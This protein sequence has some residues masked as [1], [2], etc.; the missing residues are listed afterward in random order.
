MCSDQTSCSE[1]LAPP[2]AKLVKRIARGVV[3]A[4][5]PGPSG[6]HD[7]DI[8]AIGL[9]GRTSCATRLDRHLDS[10]AK[11]W[12]SA[13]TA[14]LDCGPKKPEPGQQ[15]PQPCPRKLHPLA[16]AEVLVKLA[17]SCANEQHI[18]TLLKGVEPTNLGL[19]T[20]D[21]AAPVVRIVRGWAND[22]VVARKEGQDADVV[23]PVDLENAYGRAFRSTCLE[24]ARSA[25][26]QLA[27]ICAAQWEPC[28]TRFWQRCDDGWTVDGT[29]RGR[30]QG[31]Q[32]PCKLCLCLGCSLRSPSRTSWLHTRSRGLACR[33]T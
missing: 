18:D 26:P 3:L 20:P 28:D 33:I 22:M 11:L 7:A 15:M 17:E 1:I 32:G 9:S 14:P 2:P 13:S 31:F 5:E 21:A 6:W 24:A 8:A 16:M 25:C 30:W 4:A 29:T 23:L 19:G 27:A 12:T 10:S